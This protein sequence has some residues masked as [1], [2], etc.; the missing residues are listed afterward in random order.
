MY[1]FWFFSKI[2]VQS[3]SWLKALWADSMFTPP[4]KIS[5]TYVLLLFVLPFDLHSWNVCESWIKTI[6]PGGTSQGSQTLGWKRSQTAWRGSSLKCSSSNSSQSPQ[7]GDRGA[8]PPDDDREGDQ[9]VHAEEEEGQTQVDPSHWNGHSWGEI[10]VNL[11][12]FK[13]SAKSVSTPIKRPPPSPSLIVCLFLMKPWA[14][15]PLPGPQAQNLAAPP[16]SEQST[17][18]FVSNTQNSHLTYLYTLT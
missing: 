18:V 5:S 8:D 9:R 4:H 15:F 12:P 2:S 13:I 11:W 10:H 17:F 14:A 3:K 6:C 1:N 7:I 16:F